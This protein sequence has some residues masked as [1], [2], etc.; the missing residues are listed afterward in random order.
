MRRPLLRRRHQD[1][2]RSTSLGRGLQVLLA[3]GVAVGVTLANPSVASAYNPV[4]ELTCKYDNRTYNACL[5]ISSTGDSQSWD[6]HVGIDVYMSPQD[7]QRIAAQ[8][9][10]FFAYVVASDG[11][12]DNTLFSLPATLIA[13][14]DTGIGAEFD[15]NVLS[16]ALNEDAYPQNDEIYV[17]IKLYDARTGTYRTWTTNI[18]TNMF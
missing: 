6:I 3:M 10:S 2:G 12:Y 17:L 14:G 11:L 8:P 15:R 1:R 16:Q 7:A 5:L 9:S 4:D 13:A 18:V